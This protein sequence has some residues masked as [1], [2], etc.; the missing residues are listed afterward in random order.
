MSSSGPSS[1]RFQPVYRRYIWGGRRLNTVLGKSIGS[2]DDYAESWE[3]VDHGQDQSVVVAG[4]FA[5]RTLGELVRSD[6]PWLLGPHCGATS[7]PLLLKYLDCN[8]DL[9][10]QVHPDDT[11]AAMLDPPDLG[12]TEAWCILD[13]RPGSKVY[14]GLRPGVDSE[15]FQQAVRRMMLPPSR[16]LKP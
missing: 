13:A 5:G 2:G 4:P 15:A 1:L 16:M 7:F 6:R 14:A 9:S 11:R 3:V 10:V 8:R 12:K